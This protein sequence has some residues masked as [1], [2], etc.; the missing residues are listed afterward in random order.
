MKI[1]GTAAQTLRAASLPLLL[2]FGGCA[3]FTLRDALNVADI[4]VPEECTE[5]CPEE[6][7]GTDN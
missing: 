2:L 1:F 4:I 3:D 5:D 6:D 7:D